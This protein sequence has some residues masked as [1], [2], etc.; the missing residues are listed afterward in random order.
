MNILLSKAARGRPEGPTER[1]VFKFFF[2]MLAIFWLTFWHHQQQNGSPDCVR[3]LRSAREKWGEFYERASARQMKWE[4]SH[5]L[6]TA[7]RASA[8]QCAPGEMGRISRSV[9]FLVAAGRKTE[10]RKIRVL[11]VLKT[12]LAI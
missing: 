1:S 3:I 5:G 4:E 9:P 12:F 10:R 2:V 6:Y 8:R 11:F 7:K